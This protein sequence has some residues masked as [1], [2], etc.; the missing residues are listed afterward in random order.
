MSKPTDHEPNAQELARRVL[1][2]ST[3]KH[4][5]PA[6][7]DADLQIFEKRLG[8]KLPATLR[9]LLTKTNGGETILARHPTPFVPQDVASMSA[10]ALWQHVLRVWTE[11]GEPFAR[12]ANGHQGKLL[13]IGDDW[14]GDQYALRVREGSC[15]E[16][17]RA[18]AGSPLE[19]VEVAPDFGRFVRDA[20]AECI[21]PAP[22]PPAPPEALP[23]RGGDSRVIKQAAHAL[24]VEALDAFRQFV[25]G[26]NAGEYL[27]LR[28]EPESPW[29]FRHLVRK[30]PVPSFGWRRMESPSGFHI[31]SVNETKSGGAFEVA[32]FERPSEVD[33]AVAKLGPSQGQDIF[34]MEK[35]RI[36]KRSERLVIFESKPH[37]LGDLFCYVTLIQS[38]AAAPQPLACELQLWIRGL[39]AETSESALKVLLAAGPRWFEGDQT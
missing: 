29:S 6:A 38:S 5:A 19:L 7:S 36:S 17:V 2:L 32:S 23:P 10:D 34:S 35:M 15:R 16:V 20:I 4:L 24:Q 25:P 27:W 18:E 28:P 14:S 11:M 1:E 8:L 26:I 30:T 33:D 21:A 9:T 3:P 31:L 39:N 12:W 37:P 13:P 22:K